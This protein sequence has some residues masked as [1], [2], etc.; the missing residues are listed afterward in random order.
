[1]RNSGDPTGAQRQGTRLVSIRMRIRFLAAFGGLRI[2]HCCGCGKGWQVHL[3]FNPYPRTSV[4]RETNK[5]IKKKK[6]KKK[7]NNHK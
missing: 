6:K 1:M 5:K 3:H 7:K 2:W 4:C